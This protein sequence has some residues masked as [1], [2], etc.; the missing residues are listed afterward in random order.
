M[1][2]LHGALLALDLV[3]TLLERPICDGILAKLLELSEQLTKVYFFVKLLK[4][5]D[6]VRFFRIEL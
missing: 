1:P 2:L 6:A 5:F 3:F 4:P